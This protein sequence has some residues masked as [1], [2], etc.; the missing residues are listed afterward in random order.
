MV[1]RMRA[2]HEAHRHRLAGG[3]AR[4]IDRA[5]IAR[6]VEVD[7][8]FRAA[9]QH[10]PAD[11]DIGPAG[12]RIDHEVGRRR[13][14]GRAVGA[15]LEMDG[16]RGQVGVV[17]G[18]HDLLRRRFGARDFDDLRLVAQAPL[19]FPQQ[20]VRR[21]AEGARD[22][23]AAAVTLP[24]S[25]WRSGPAASNITARG[26]PPACRDVGEFDR[27]RM[28]R[29][30]IRPEELLRNVRSRKRSK[31]IAAPALSTTFM[32]SPGFQSRSND[33]SA[34]LSTPAPQAGN[35][36]DSDCLAATAHRGDV[37]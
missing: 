17:A 32:T 16:Q 10:Q 6:R 26:F 14:I 19:D 12:L 8:G 5:Q 9:A 28:G 34:A 3:R 37:D 22:A 1:D 33:N 25:C 4:L 7:A 20:L 23:A 15:V 35:D 31:S 27:L 24:T 18:Q 30:L 13:D 11:A 36:R 2:D 29:E 21:D